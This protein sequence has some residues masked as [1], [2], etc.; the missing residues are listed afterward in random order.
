MKRG[1]W[2]GGGG[3]ENVL[4]ERMKTKLEAL[5]E[6]ELKALSRMR[7]RGIERERYKDNK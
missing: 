6:R 4:E 5:M 1:W 7:E 3:V 2:D